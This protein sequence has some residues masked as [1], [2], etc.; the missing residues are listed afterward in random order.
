MGGMG[1]CLRDVCEKARARP[2][3]FVGVPYREFS[4]LGLVSRGLYIDRS[5]G[6]FSHDTSIV[7]EI[8]VVYTT[9][10]TP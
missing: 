1:S 4:G 7:R 5:D 10:S 3:W 8:L 9:S 6:F 2:T